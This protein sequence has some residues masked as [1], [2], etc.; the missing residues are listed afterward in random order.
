M[1][2]KLALSSTVRLAS[3]YTMPLLGLG[4]FRCDDT[5]PSVLEA[6]KAGYRSINIVQ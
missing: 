5:K 3:G 4:V 2:T 6:L 1:T